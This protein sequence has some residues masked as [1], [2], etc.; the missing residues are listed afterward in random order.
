[1]TMCASGCG[2][3]IQPGPPH[4]KKPRRYCSRRCANR[5]GERRR[6]PRRR[7]AYRNMVL[8]L[9]GVECDC[10]GESDPAFLTVDHPNGGGREHRAKIGTSI[11]YK[12]LLDHNAPD[13]FRLLCMN[14][15]W[16]RRFTG[17]C[18]HEDTRMQDRARFYTIDGREYPSVTTIL[19]V[20]DRSAPLMHWAAAQERKA[21]EGAL[22]DVLSR[23]EASGQWKLD[24]VFA[25]I[26]KALPAKRAFL[27]AS[28]QAADIGLAAHKLIQ[29][30]TQKMLGEYAGDEPAVPDP[31]LRAVLS[32]LDWC[33][34]VDFTPLY[35][36]R[37]IHC[38]SCA[39]AGTFDAVAKVN[40]R[41]T[42]LDWKTGKAVYPEAFLQNIAYRHAATREGIDT[43]A[44]LI[45]RLPKTAEDPGFEAV[46]AK[47]IPYRAWLGA[48][49]L[50]RWQRWMR[51][52]ETGTEGMSPCEVET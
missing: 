46:P 51:G 5:I 2:A 52:E 35:T 48:C 39:F 11:F 25:E 17:R 14:C 16:A 28:E 20:I 37:V 19:R 6:S 36:E 3:I 13:A 33:K 45:L 30:H 4:A 41:V 7:A 22:L 43:E 47:P 27:K 31:A 34:A 12:W 23:A 9:Y 38:P 44:G 8:F 18:P 24:Q 42:M 21:F 29:W 15:N 32:W 50:W 49:T 1:M 40:G 10:C 26:V